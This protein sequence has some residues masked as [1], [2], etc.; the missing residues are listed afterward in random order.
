MELPMGLR[1]DRQRGLLMELQ[2]DLRRDLL[3]NL[4]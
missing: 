3:M 1:T 4:L 2:K